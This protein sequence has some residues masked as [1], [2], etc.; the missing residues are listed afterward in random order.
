MSSARREVE[1]D[2]AQGLQVAVALADVAHLD[3]GVGRDCARMVG[4]AGRHGIGHV[5]FSSL[6]ETVCTDAKT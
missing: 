6:L 3:D 5:T 4:R 2:A 1:I